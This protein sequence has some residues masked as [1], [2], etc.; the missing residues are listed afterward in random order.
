M[1]TPTK[2]ELILTA[3][4]ITAKIAGLDSYKK[5]R[6]SRDEAEVKQ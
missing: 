5:I 1:Q 2:P 3:W 4:V 6:I